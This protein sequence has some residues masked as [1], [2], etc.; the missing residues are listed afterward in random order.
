MSAMR[1]GRWQFSVRSLLLMLACSSLAFAVIPVLGVVAGSTAAIML[2]VYLILRAMPFRA[3]LIGTALIALMFITSVILEWPYGNYL[4]A[5]VLDVVSMIIEVIA[6]IAYLPVNLLS[7]NDDW[8]W[9]SRY[10]DLPRFTRE[11]V[12]VV[13]WLQMFASAV[14]A[15][16]ASHISRRRARL[17]NQTH[18]VV[19]EPVAAVAARSDAA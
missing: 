13:F 18:S 19:D 5:P 2:V 8:Y 16:V 4:F 10:H 3:Q 15:M 11:E 12:V 9:Y 7:V 1:Y 14:L 17:K 6:T